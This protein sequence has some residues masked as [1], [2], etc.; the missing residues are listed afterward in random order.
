MVLGNAEIL[1]SISI[2][3]LVIFIGTIIIVYNKLIKKE[4]GKGLPPQ[5]YFELFDIEIYSLLKGYRNNDYEGRVVLNGVTYPPLNQKGF[6]YPFGNPLKVNLAIGLGVR[7]YIKDLASGTTILD[8]SRA[9]TSEDMGKKKLYLCDGSITNELISDFKFL[10]SG[11]W[12]T[13]NCGN[14]NIIISWNSLPLYK[15]KFVTDSKL[16]CSNLPRDFITPY[17]YGDISSSEVGW[18]G[19]WEG[20]IWYVQTSSGVGLGSAQVKDSKNPILS[21]SPGE[22]KMK[23]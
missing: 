5:P 8:I 1:V 9:V 3:V 18:K 4:E 19:A 20:M 7:Y 11:N 10:F 17:T 21:I 16:N 13:G 12:N 22:I 2:L 23:P 14:S 6:S 15:E